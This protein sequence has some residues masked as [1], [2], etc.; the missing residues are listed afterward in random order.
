LVV[1]F[2]LVTVGL[3]GI[4][5]AAIATTKTYD[6]GNFRAT[7]TY[8]SGNY[9]TDVGSRVTCPTNFTGHHLIQVNYQTQAVTSND[10]YAAG[11]YTTAGWHP[12][13]YYAP[14]TRFGN[15]WYYV[16]GCIPTPTSG[17]SGVPF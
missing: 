8:S 11:T 1:T 15:A 17:A 16:S 4:S 12:N 13:N 2:T 6:S 14:N 3:V 9:V 5:S 7:V 10:T